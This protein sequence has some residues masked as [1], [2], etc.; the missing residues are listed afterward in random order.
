MGR[1]KVLHLLNSLNYGGAERFLLNLSKHVDKEKFK[2]DILVRD[3][4]NPMAPFFYELG[5]DVVVAPDFPKHSL[6][7]YRYM[8]KFVKKND[9]DWVHIHANSLIYTLPFKLFSS[10]NVLL[11]SHS[12]YSTNMVV[13]KIHNINKK[14]YLKSIEVSIACSDAAGEWMFGNNQF[15]IIYNGIETERFK[16]NFEARKKTRKKLQVMES[17]VLIGTIGRLSEVK[18][19]GFAIDLIKKLNLNSETN[20]KLFIVGDGELREE[21]QTNIDEQNLNNTVMLLG[22][23]DDVPDLLSAFDIYIQP[24]W[25]EGFP[26]T[27]IEAQMSNLPTILS[28]N[29]TEESRIIKDV[30]F[31]SLSDRKKW[32]ETIEKYSKNNKNRED[33]LEVDIEKVDIKNISKEFEEIYLGNKNI[34]KRDKYVEKN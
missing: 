8:K 12:S 24:S 17:E 10:S 14:K 26:F 19:F 4:N 31:V 13:K 11:H 29:I 7:H 25:F 16:Y 20:Y 1:V 34:I 23:R 3:E 27:V 15:E 32:L 5:D 30:R 6:N 28:D 2:F 21:L 33:Y 22:N 18:N 9:Y